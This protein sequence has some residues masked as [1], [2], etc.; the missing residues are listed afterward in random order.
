MVVVVAEEDGGCACAWWLAATAGSLMSVAMD[1]SWTYSAAAGCGDD[2]DGGE[3]IRAGRVLDA[4][5]LDA[6]AAAVASQSA[7]EDVYWCWCSA[8][9]SVTED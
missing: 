7:V 1:A 6:A 4:V 8:G 5:L 3:G 9:L 2:D